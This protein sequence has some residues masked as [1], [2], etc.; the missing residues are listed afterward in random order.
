[1]LG[2]RNSKANEPSNADAITMPIT[3]QRID[4]IQ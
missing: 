1:L 2:I 3:S 4:P